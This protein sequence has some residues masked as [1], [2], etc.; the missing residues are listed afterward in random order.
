MS[1][2]PTISVSFQDILDRRAYIRLDGE[3]RVKLAHMA[4]APWNDKAPDAKLHDL[5]QEVVHRREREKIVH[6]GSRL[7]KS[8]LGGVEAI[9]ELMLP[10]SKLAVVAQRYDHVGAE[11]Q[12]VY[13]GM[14]NLFDGRRHAFK[15]L[16]FKHQANYHDY[17]CETIWGSRGRG[18]S[19]ESDDGAALLGQEFS[20]VILGEGSHISQEILEKRVLRA[21]DGWLMQSTEGLIREG[22]YLSIYTTPKGFEG[23]SAAE[24]E[25][26]MKQTKRRPELLHYGRTDFASSVWIRE[27]SVLENPFYDRN[28]YEA[29]KRSVGK[30]AFSEQWEGKMTFKTGRVF[31]SYDEDI[32]LRPAPD[33]AELRTMRLGVGID[34]GAY[35]GLVLAGIGR[36]SRMWALAE[37][38]T[39]QR[40]IDE[41]LDEFRREVVRALAPALLPDWFVDPDGDLETVQEAFEKL[42]PRID[43]W[44]V[45]PASQHKLEIMA[46]LG[47]IALAT[48]VGIEGGKL[49]LIPSVEAMD[50]WF[51][52]GLVRVADH[53][54]DLDDQLRRYIWKQKKAAGRGAARAPV[55]IEPRKEYDHLVDALRFIL[56]MLKTMGPL[57]E[58]PPPI[59]IKE[60]WERAQR[61]RIF[62]PLREMMRRARQAEG[63][64]A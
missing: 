32:H 59:T 17:D 60:A 36:D 4:G 29:R 56:V 54:T 51:K 28:V 20:R 10:F 43:V 44:S 30:A 52:A 62:G 41:S 48:P 37:T 57:E 2:A 11:W 58:P 1:A 19:V 63:H 55:V 33:P 31:K 6:G 38:Y 21:L 9:C 61:E 26:V 8:V 39:Q 3:A 27:A 12:Y 42:L 24:W 50:E 7:G 16:I 23:C 45:D 5:Q 64:W 47:D 35:T 15:R 53:C 49:E 18:Y 34:T 14:L 46:N 13:R 25:R 22:G 40:T